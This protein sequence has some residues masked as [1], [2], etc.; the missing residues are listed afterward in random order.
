MNEYT[1]PVVLR[2]PSGDER[3][4]FLGHGEVLTF[5]TGPF[6]V[7]TAHDQDRGRTSMLE[8]IRAYVRAGWK[9]ES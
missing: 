8:A 7:M 2:S 6:P 3:K 4:T 1:F 5:T 9:V